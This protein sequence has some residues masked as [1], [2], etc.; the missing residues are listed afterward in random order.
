MICSISLI[1]SMKILYYLTYIKINKENEFT[2]FY[3]SI[4]IT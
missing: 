3:I 1:D 4:I 2:I